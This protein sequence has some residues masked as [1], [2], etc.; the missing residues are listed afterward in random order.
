MK[1]Q[2]CK[3]IY[4]ACRQIPQLSKIYLFF[5]G[6]HVKKSLT[7]PQVYGKEHGRIPKQE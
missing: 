6:N 1:K 7:F 2:H 3:H 4:S 5:G